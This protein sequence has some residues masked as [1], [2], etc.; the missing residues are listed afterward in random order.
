MSSGS[1]QKPPHADEQMRAA[2]KRLRDIAW[3]VKPLTG[4]ADDEAPETG[5]DE[6]DSDEADSLVG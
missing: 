5:A 6:A 1:E 3:S 2:T 4:T